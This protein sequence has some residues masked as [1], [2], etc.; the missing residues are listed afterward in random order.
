MEILL[1]NDG[2][3]EEKVKVLN[4]LVLALMMEVEALREALIE[5]SKSKGVLPKDSAY[6]QAYRR[7]A[8]LTHN[9]AGPSS[10]VRKILSLWFTTRASPNDMDLREALMLIRLGFS[11]SEIGR[12]GEEAEFAEMLT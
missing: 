11:P 12:F 1:S 5:E 10:G 3:S 9:N 8:L 4:K 6:G 2:N 7:T